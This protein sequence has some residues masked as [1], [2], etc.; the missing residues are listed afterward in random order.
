[1]GT[2]ICPGKSSPFQE[3]VASMKSANITLVAQNDSIISALGIMM[4]K[5]V[6]TSRSSNISQNMRN[7]ARLLISL[8]EAEPLKKCPAVAVSPS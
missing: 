8:R 3:V 4:V 6:G 5:K 1:M 2:L 7:L